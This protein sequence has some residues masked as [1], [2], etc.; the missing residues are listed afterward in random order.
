MVAIAMAWFFAGLLQPWHG[1]CRVVAAVAWSVQSWHGF[2]GSCGHSMV[3]VAV[4]AVA[5]W[6]L[7]WQH[8]LVVVV[9]M[10]TV[11]LLLWWVVVW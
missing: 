3:L 4:M 1:F 9:A 2:G 10:A 7:W 11:W 8:S 5:W 6:L